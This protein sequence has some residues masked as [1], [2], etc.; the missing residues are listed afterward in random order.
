MAEQRTPGGKLSRNKSSDPA[1]LAATQIGGGESDLAGARTV[2]SDIP[3]AAGPGWP[4]ASPF[5]FGSKSPPPG[6]QPEAT[7]TETVVMEMEPKAPV[8][9]AWLA[10][11]EGPGGKRGK[12]LTLG[13]ETIVGRTHGDLLLSGDRGVSSQH[14][15][16]RLETRE[17][18]AETPPSQ[19]FVA[20]DM[21]STNGTYVGSRATYRDEASRIYRKELKDG[22]YLLVGDT[23]LV[24]K[25]A[26]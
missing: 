22:D 9:L 16:V 23:T 20:Y 3:A 11:V 14:L 4:P 21:A 18:S 17:G 6:S 7:G 15:K 19:V 10:I 5:P 25:Q 13:L 2:A 1:E 24:F 12:V 8:P 26:E